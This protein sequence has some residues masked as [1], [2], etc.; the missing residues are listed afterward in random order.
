[1]CS[2]FDSGINMVDIVVRE[3]LHTHSSIY[4]LTGDSKNNPLS[5]LEDLLRKE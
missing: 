4:I 5:E 2:S 3:F 1:V